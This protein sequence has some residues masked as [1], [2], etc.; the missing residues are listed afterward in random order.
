MIRAKERD[1]LH[2]ARDFNTPLSALERYS[3]QKIHKETLDLICTLDQ[4]DLIDT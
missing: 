4:M 2:I 3:R 1:R